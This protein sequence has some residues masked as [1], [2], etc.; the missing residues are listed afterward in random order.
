MLLGTSSN[1]HVNKQLIESEEIVFT[2]N[3]RF[4]INKTSE[5]IHNTNANPG[6]GIRLINDPTNSVYIEN[7]ELIFSENSIV[8]TNVLYGPIIRQHGLIFIAKIKRNGLTGLI[9]VGYDNNTINE[10]WDS[11]LFNN[12]SLSLR[13]NNKIINVLNNSISENIEYL[14]SIVVR[15]FGAFYFIKGG[16]FASWT[17]LYIDDNSKISNM[18]AGIS[19]ISEPVDKFK[20]AG[21][22]ISNNYWVPQPIISD[23]FSNDNISDGCGH[24]EGKNNL[25][26]YGGIGIKYNNQ[27]TSN[28]FIIKLLQLTNKNFYGTVKLNIENN[29]AGFILKY[30]DE[31]NHILIQYDKAYVSL[32][33]VING[34][35]VVKLMTP[36]NNS[37]N[38]INKLTIDVYNNIVK[39]YLNDMF[40]S[41]E[42]IDYSEL[43][44]S[45][46]FG[47]FSTDVSNAF[48]DFSIYDKDSKYA[49]L[50][51]Y[52]V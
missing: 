23:N 25:L 43:N 39:I 5:E 6:P 2:I 8:G 4:S 24:Y 26:G 50:D 37:S 52:T 46:N 21:I 42:N 45:N 22:V 48:K 49:R 47:L 1:V 10:M 7:K 15:Q 40:I 12:K 36:V 34:I 35:S 13:I 32:I 14:V 3:D 28:N 38:N 44:E 9:E 18:Y 19:V 51:L 17:L 41:E 33:E 30:V 27:L 16:K 31:N 20:S 11:I 29:T